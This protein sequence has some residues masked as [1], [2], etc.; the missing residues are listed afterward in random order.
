MD[1]QQLT[2]VSAAIA[3]KRQLSFDY[4]KANGDTARRLVEPY[5]LVDT[6]RR[7]YLVAWDVDREDWRT[8]RADRIASLPVERRKYSP[9]PLPANDLADYVQRSVTRSPYRYD[10][11]VRLH[12]PL[13]EVAA[14]VG[15]QLASLSDDGGNAT[16]LRA[17][18]DS[19]AQ[20]A[21]HLASLGMDFEII[22]P[23]EFKDYART[24]AA[25]LGKAAGT[26]VLQAE[27][28][29]Q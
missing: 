19:L 23:E 17:G 15:P 2:V 28:P 4:A 7:W 11:V 22:A 3:D 16:L 12:A 13:G 26:R 9:R 24:M 10:V 8:F 29:P 20:P 18:W 27:A 1:P 5:G 14:V 25:R 6:G 21:A